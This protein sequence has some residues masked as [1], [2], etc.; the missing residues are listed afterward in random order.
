MNIDAVKAYLL[1]LQANLCQQLQAYELNQ[2]FV[3]DSWERDGGG[4]GITRVLQGGDVFES[5]GVNFSHVAGE[6]LPPAATKLRPE[7]VNAQFQAMGVSSV[8]HPRNP[9]VPTCHLNVRL[10]CAQ[11]PN[12]KWIWWFGGGFDLTPYYPEREDVLH[13]HRM[14]KAACDPFGA[15]IYPEYKAWADRY[16]YLP[17]RKE[18]RGVGGLF[19]DDLNTATWGW[20]FETCFAFLRSVGTHFW[21]SYG[22]IV[23]RQHQRPYSERETDFQH[24]RRGRYVEFNLVYDRGTLFGLQSGGRTESVLMSLPPQVNFEY[25]RKALPGTPEKELVDYYLRVQD[26]LKMGE[27]T[28]TSA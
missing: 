8:I 10:F 11:D 20:D 12:G 6:T 3:T 13:F 16:F 1:Q 24:Y 27:K 5:A 17:H 19:F 2:A 22:P 23:Q 25:Q 9:Y 28:L 26:W 14:A 18:A 21:K 4:G 15:E 7:L